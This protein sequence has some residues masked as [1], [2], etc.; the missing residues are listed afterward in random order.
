VVVE[1]VDGIE[2]IIES[3]MT[4]REE[5]SVANVEIEMSV[6]MV[7]EKVTEKRDDTGVA[8]VN[9]DKSRAPNLIDNSL[10]IGRGYHS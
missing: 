1:A 6:E 2:K 3:E 7:K 10:R 9:V 8:M 5:N 4:E